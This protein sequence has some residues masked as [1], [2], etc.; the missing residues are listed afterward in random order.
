[1]PHVAHI[2]PTLGMITQDK[3]TQCLKCEACECARLF[4]SRSCTGFSPCDAQNQTL[5][6]NRGPGA[7]SLL[8]QAFGYWEVRPLGFKL[9]TVLSCDLV[10]SSCQDR[11]EGEACL[12]DVLGSQFHGEAPFG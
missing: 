1:M 9:F 5:D 12:E 8:E 7:E 6:V 3:L 2:E 4:L 11:L 10:T